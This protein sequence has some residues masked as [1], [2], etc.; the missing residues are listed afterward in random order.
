MLNLFMQSIVNAFPTLALE[1]YEYRRRF[2]A[3]ASFVVSYFMI[4][5]LSLSLQVC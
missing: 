3:R 1:S 5:L 4:Y 2:V